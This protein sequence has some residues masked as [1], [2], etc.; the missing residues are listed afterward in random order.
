M[1]CSAIGSLTNV[2]KLTN[3][4]RSVKNTKVSNDTIADYLNFLTEAFLFHQAKRYDIKG[5]KYFEYPSKYYCTD[6][7]LRNVRLG[8]RQQ[9]E[10]HIMENVIYNELLAR[11]FSVDVGVVEIVSVGEDGKRRQKQCLYPLQNG[12]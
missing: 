6:V 11:G 10:T 7:G 12:F 4:L 8:L 5:K 1:L 3:T 9:E 2:S